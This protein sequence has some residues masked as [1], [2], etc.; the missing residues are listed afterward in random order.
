MTPSFQVN[1]GR[2]TRL[3]M[4][5]FSSKAIH[6]MTKNT[7]HYISHFRSYK[8]Q[9]LTTEQIYSEDGFMMKTQ[10]KSTI[11]WSIS[12]LIYLCLIYPPFILSK[13][14]SSENFIKGD[15]YFYHATVLSILND[16]DL[17]LENNISAYK[18]NGDLAMGK[19]GLVPKHPIL[20]PLVSLP[21][22]MLFE[23][24]GLLLFNI[25]NCIVISILIFYINNLFFS[26][27]V[28]FITTIVYATGTLFFEYVYNYSPD[29]FSTTLVLSGLYLI[30]IKK[31]SIGVFILGLSIF[32]KISNAPI[33][34]M[35]LIYALF[36]IKREKIKDTKEKSSD[37][38]IK[39]ILVI[40]MI[41]LIS[42]IPFA[43]TNYI[44]FDSPFI[45]GYQRT[46]IEIENS[47]IVILTHVDK[48]NQPIISGILSLLFDQRTGIILTNPIIIIAMI[49]VFYI[50]T[51]V[52]HQYKV[53]L[54]ILICLTQFILFA[55]YDEA[56]MSHF[57][58]R[59]LMTFIALSSIF[60]S[61]Y[62]NHLIKKLSILFTESMNTNYE[63]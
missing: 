37:S 42:L 57:S 63:T 26:H 30:L 7:Q 29:I 34:L 19:H 15:A 47:E 4:K 52:K 3:C 13:I 35:M 21:F 51:F 38:E 56:L 27:L 5:P 9:I 33:V 24:Q 49:G 23:I 14:A 60:T 62:F 1:F 54:I 45:T 58:N 2:L 32:A 6:Y 61:A 50:K 48:F 31:M 22:Y 36:I 16:G 53:V 8:T 12:I 20:M 43:Y 28:S 40:V 11:L 46:A 55:K 18:L 41:F 44:L 59:F 25:L 17:L 39:T 10:Q